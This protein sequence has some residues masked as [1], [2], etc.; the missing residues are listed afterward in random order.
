MD[1]GHTEFRPAQTQ[2]KKAFNL[3][4]FLTFS[5]FIFVRDTSDP[6][7]PRPI[8]LAHLSSDI[9]VSPHEMGVLLEFR[10]HESK[11][12]NKV[13]RAEKIGHKSH[14]TQGFIKKVNT[15]GKAE[16]LDVSLTPS[17]AE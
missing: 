14:V 4:D 16:R 6:D 12:R 10:G 2:K 17:S 8:F 5:H 1:V 9:D 7:C 11:T 3:P 15:I 13:Q